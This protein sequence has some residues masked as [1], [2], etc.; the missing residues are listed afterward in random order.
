MNVN[1]SPNSRGI[2]VGSTGSGKS[3]LAKAII[4][5][6]PHV[7]AIDP[8]PSLGLHDPIGHLAGFALSRSPDELREQARSYAWLQYRPDSAYQTADWYDRIYAWAFRCG[9]RYVYTDELYLATPSTF[10]GPGLMA[11]ITS[12]RERGIGMLH[13]TQRPTRIDQRAISECEYFY[14]FSLRKPEDRKRMAD[15]S[16][17]EE[18]REPA[19]GHDFWFVGPEQ[20]AIIQRLSPRYLSSRG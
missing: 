12:G 16:G 1:P 9:N 19:T 11:C 7:L 5:R 4:R 15:C 2:C 3:T 18:L 13:A 6:F 17:F 10:A 8:K 20:D 14:T